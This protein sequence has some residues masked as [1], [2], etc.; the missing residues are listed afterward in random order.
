MNQ[1][2]VDQILTHNAGQADKATARERNVE[3]ARR[4]EIA[5][6]ADELMER[7]PDSMQIAL[8]M[9]LRVAVHATPPL[10][11]TSRKALTKTLPTLLAH[12]NTAINE[13][14]LDELVGRIERDAS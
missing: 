11:D 3:A 14:W 13:G 7:L 8:R 6:Q 9:R 12:I 10:A 2:R 1:Q 5:A 4:A